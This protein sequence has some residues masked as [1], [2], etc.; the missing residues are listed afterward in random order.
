MTFNS[1]FFFI[2]AFVNLNKLYIRYLYLL[3]ISFILLGTHD[4]NGSPIIT[5]EAEK[6]ITAGVNGYEIA[7]VLLY[8]GTIPLKEEDD[9][10]DNRL[11]YIYLVYYYRFDCT[12]FCV[13]FFCSLT[14]PYDH[15]TFYIIVDVCLNI[16]K[17]IYM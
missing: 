14:N 6:L 11:V 17:S 15:A 8:Y 2:G 9:D 16:E 5:I 12:F 13:F 10:P 4:L 7:T 1:F 3:F